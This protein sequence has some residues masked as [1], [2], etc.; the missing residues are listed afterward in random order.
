MSKKKVSYN[1]TLATPPIAH[2][3]HE[4]VTKEELQ[5][6]YGKELNHFTREDELRKLAQEYLEG[7]SKVNEFFNGAVQ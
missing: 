4:K 3:I 2:D 7:E 1:L 5:K 6:W